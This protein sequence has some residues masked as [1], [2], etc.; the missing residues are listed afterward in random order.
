MERASSRLTKLLLRPTQKPLEDLFCQGSITTIYHQP[1]LAKFL[2][3]FG[4]MPPEG[5]D[6]PS[7]V[8]MTARHN[9]WFRSFGGH[10]MSSRWGPKGESV[11]PLTVVMDI[12]QDTDTGNGSRIVYVHTQTLLFD[13]LPVPKYFFSMELTIDVIDGGAEES[14]DLQVHGRMFDR[15]LFS[16]KGRMCITDQKQHR[17]LHDVVLFDGACVLCDRSVDFLIERDARKLIA[18]G[19]PRFKVAAIQSEVGR[20]FI[21]DAK[22]DPK[23]VQ[24]LDSMLLITSTG[25]VYSRSDAA[26]RIATGLCFP[27]PL[28]GYAGLLLPRIL[29]DA[30]YNFVAGHRIQWFGA[31]EL[32][33]CTPPKSAN[34]QS[35]L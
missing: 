23:L 18:P 29:C 13:L 1:L 10:F 22:V 12:R 17:I 28:L 21:D 7:A 24:K 14:W 4:V 6:V 35:Y 11:G 3:L 8:C 31:K 15:L 19:L 34:R 26:L 9:A 25:Q 33:V 2:Q 16:E 30:V 5:K 27:Y 32:D 20:Q